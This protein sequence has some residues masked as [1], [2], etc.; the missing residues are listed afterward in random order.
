VQLKE[1]LV[2]LLGLF[3]ARG[4]APPCHPS[5]RLSAQRVFS[6]KFSPNAC[7]LQTRVFSARVFS[8]RVFSPSFT[9]LFDDFTQKFFIEVDRT[10]DA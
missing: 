8:K 1:V 3:G 6:P 4:I 9:L 5:L 2:E 7:F 10:E